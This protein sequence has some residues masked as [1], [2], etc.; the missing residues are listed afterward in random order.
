MLFSWAVLRALSSWEADAASE[1]LYDICV[2]RSRGEVRESLENGGGS[3]ADAGAGRWRVL[4]GT[5]CSTAIGIVPQTLPN[6]GRL[7]EYVPVP[8]K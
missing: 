6:D 4:E 5:S 8:A 1:N 7:H 2:V 3:A